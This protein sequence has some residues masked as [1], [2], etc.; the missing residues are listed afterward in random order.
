[1][2]ADMRLPA[3]S[4]RDS[5]RISEEVVFREIGGEAVILDMRHGTYFGLDPVGT[6]IWHL[7]AQ[8]GR[9]ARVFDSLL[10]EFDVSSAVLE[11]DLTSL[12]TRLRERHLLQQTA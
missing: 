2:S 11:A 9:L 3:V 5:Y 1:M 10:E 7:I 6:R 8:H 4:L 12:V